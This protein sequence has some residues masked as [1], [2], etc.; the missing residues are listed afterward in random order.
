MAGYTADNVDS[1][2]AVYPQSQYPP[3]LFPGNEIISY[4]PCDSGSSLLYSAQLT[5]N[6]QPGESACISPSSELDSRITQGA[7]CQAYIPSCQPANIASGNL[8]V[9]QEYREVC[10]IC[11]RS[12]RNLSHLKIHERT[13][14]GEKTISCPKRCGKTFNIKSNM[15][16][17]YVICQHAQGPPTVRSPPHEDPKKAKGAYYVCERCGV[18]EKQPDSDSKRRTCDACFVD[19]GK[20]RSRLRSGKRAPLKS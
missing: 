4:R 13:H 18:E 20:Y 3:S 1:C 10:K 9:G 8:A 14:S 17:H 19:A 12:F 11:S 6:D 5:R 7:L 15:R 16:R 2:D